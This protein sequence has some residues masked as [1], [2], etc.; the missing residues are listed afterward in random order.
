MKL[1]S[2]SR[3]VFLPVS[4]LLLVVIF[5]F[6]ENHAASLTIWEWLGTIVGLAPLFA[7]QFALGSPKILEQTHRWLMNKKN[8]VLVAGLLLWG[9]Y[10]VSGISNSRLNPYTSIIFLFGILAAFGTLRQIE[11]G[12]MGLTWADAAIWLLLWIPFDLRGTEKLWFG[13]G[14]LSY[15]WWSATV[16]VVGVTG[17]A[18][19]REL[20]DFGYRLIPKKKDFTAALFALLGVMVIIVPVGLAIGFLHFPPSTPVRIW[21]IVGGF[22]GLFLTVAIPEE[23]FFRGI[24]LHGLD[25]MSSKRWLTLLLSS[26][27]FGLMHWNNAADL[28]TRI[29]YVSLATIA[30]CFYGWA[31]R[32]SGNNLL[33]AVLVHTLTDLL[34]RSALQ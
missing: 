15:T 25:Q 29:F 34:W 8:P 21:G 14:W 30:G 20:P 17:W 12:K 3:W 18:L 9:L 2:I 4:G 22:I 16:S 32:R 19:F 13:A 6:A 10:L 28:T 5:I 27:A 11:T 24:L 33:A 23:L 7:L 26:L 1:S 31:Y